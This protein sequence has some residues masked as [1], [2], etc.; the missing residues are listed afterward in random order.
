MNSCI[1]EKPPPEF[2]SAHHEGR[3]TAAASTPSWA[4][5]EEVLIDEGMSAIGAAKCCRSARARGC[6]PAD[7]AAIVE[8]WRPLKA[9]F[10]SPLGALYSRILYARAGQ[11]HSSGWPG[12]GRADPAAERAAYLARQEAADRERAEALAKF[13]RYRPEEEDGNS[14]ETETRREDVG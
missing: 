12:Q 1:S 11:D 3:A 13:E 5:E 7:V 4:E 8:A 14:C 9:R 2:D 10:T 6:A